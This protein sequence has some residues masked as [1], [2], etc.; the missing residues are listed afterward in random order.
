MILDTIVALATPPLMSAIGVVRMSGNQAFA[1]AETLRGAPFPQA[2][3]QLVRATLTH[4]DTH[5][6]VDDVLISTFRAPHSYTGE[7][8]IEFSCHGNVLILNEVL[9]LCLRYGARLAEPGEFTNRAYWNG[10]IDLIQAESINDTIQARSTAAKNL[11]LQGVQ[12][13]V[14]ARVHTLRQTLLQVLATIEVNIDY[15]EYDD[16][17]QMT[18]AALHPPLEQAITELGKTLQEAEIGRAIRNGIK[19]AIVGRPNVGKSSLLNALIREE[20]AIVTEI[21]GTTRD[22][23]EGQAVLYGIPFQFLD[24]AGIRKE[25]ESIEQL[26]IEKS[27]RMMEQADLVLLVRDIRNGEDVEEQ[28]LLERLAHKPHLIVQN[29]RD[30]SSETKPGIVVSAKLK[31]TQA[32]ERAMVEVLG[33]TMSETLSIPRLSNPRQ[34]GL[35]QRAWQA[36]QD[37]KHA[38]DAHQP[39]D[40]VAIDLQQAFLALSEL[41]GEQAQ[42]DVEAEI[43]ARFCVGK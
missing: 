27:Y 34:M 22:V 13:A 17:E 25:A 12:G 20:K 38:A 40:L 6:P 39:V 14:S 42:P 4:P 35:L 37:A 16:I 10:K 36:L 33:L 8:V 29:K 21:P 41:L 15:P 23:V 1:I 7:D 18:L 9:A 19:V 30:L 2:T 5:E 24:T 31:D 3:R 28:A 43:F 32:L 26:G 11:A